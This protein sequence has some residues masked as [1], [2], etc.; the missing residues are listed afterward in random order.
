MKKGKN[1]LVVGVAGALLLSVSGVVSPLNNTFAVGDTTALNTDQDLQ[2]A[3]E[4]AIKKL[5]DYPE[6]YSDIKDLP[7]I[8][9]SKYISM[10]TDEKSK[11]EITATL[12]IVEEKDKQ[13]KA[14][15]ENAGNEQNNPPQDSGSVQQ[16]KEHKPGGQ[17]SVLNE[18]E[19]EE[20]E[21]YKQKVK[22]E[23]EKLKDLSAED[24]ATYLSLIHI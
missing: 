7:D 14:K 18:K 19:K 1:I 21:L 5:D 6:A 15:K 23:L 22:E 3:K 16:P 11:E 12:K 9:K 17:P 24:K 4:E 13:K 2:K 20:L 8:I 10:I